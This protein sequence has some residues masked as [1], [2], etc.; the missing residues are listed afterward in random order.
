MKWGCESALTLVRGSMYATLRLSEVACMPLY[1]CPREHVCNFSGVFGRARRLTSYPTIAVRP[2]G[3]SS[4]RTLHRAG[5]RSFSPSRAGWE[6]RAVLVAVP[7]AREERV[8]HPARRSLPWSSRSPEGRKRQT[9]MGLCYRCQ[10]RQKA[11]NRKAPPRAGQR[12]GWCRGCRAWQ[13]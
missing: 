11:G 8:C 5:P 9:K 4:H 12:R 1:A 2:R 13:G 10:R 6:A 3:E 7:L